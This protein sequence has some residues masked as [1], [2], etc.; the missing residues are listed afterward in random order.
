MVV[1]GVGWMQAEIVVD[2]AGSRYY[3]WCQLWNVSLQMHIS[4]IIY[5]PRA[6]L[7]PC[8]NVWIA[9]LLIATT[10]FEC[11]TEVAKHPKYLA[12]KQRS[13]NLI[14]FLT[15][16]AFAFWNNTLSFPPSP[17]RIQSAVRW[18]IKID[19]TKTRVKSEVPNAWV[20]FAEIIQRILQWL[21]NVHIFVRFTK[22]SHESCSLRLWWWWW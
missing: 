12:S 18:P 10:T 13:I 17:F 3:S 2:R 9:K 11:E 20:T 6:V 5:T 21:M 4:C 19:H 1:S 14:C 8:W 16:I 15:R 7:E 22:H